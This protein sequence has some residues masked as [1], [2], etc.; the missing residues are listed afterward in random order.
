MQIKLKSALIAALLLVSSQSLPAFSHTDHSGSSGHAHGHGAARNL[1]FPYVCDPDSDE[2]ITA[3]FVNER[4]HLTLRVDVFEVEDTFACD[5]AGSV[6]D[7]SR[8]VVFQ[9]ASAL[10]RTSGGLPNENVYLELI[11]DG[12]VFYFDTSEAIQGPTRGGYTL[13]TWTR[14]RLQLPSRPL[15]SSIGIAVIADNIGTA[16]VQGFAF[17][18]HELGKGL[19]VQTGCPWNGDEICEQNGTKLV[20]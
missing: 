1:L 11:V 16:S 7:L 8:P 13:Y 19:A 2:D 5:N 15:V 3:R 4:G 10:V 20:L 9:S 12:I 14:N 18:G 6:A 17:N